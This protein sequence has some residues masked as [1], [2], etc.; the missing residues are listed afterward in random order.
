MKLSNVRRYSADDLW[1]MDR[2]LAMQLDRY[3]HLSDISIYE[4]FIINSGEIEI[5]NKEINL[6][7]KKKKNLP[8]MLSVIKQFDL[9]KYPWAED[10]KMD[11][12]GLAIS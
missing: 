10:K 3:A 9:I 1:C 5:Q 2:G 12:T 11:F 4:K 6:K 7:F 8:L